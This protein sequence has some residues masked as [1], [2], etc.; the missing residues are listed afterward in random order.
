MFDSFVSP[1]TEVQQAALSMGFFRQEYCRGLPFPSL[2]HLPDTG[3]ESLSPT[4]AGG[5]L[6]TKPP[7]KPIM[8]E[9]SSVK[10]YICPCVF[11]HIH[12]FPQYMCLVHFSHSVVSDSL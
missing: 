5:F 3:I 1:W 12:I 4:L 8:Y 10:I 9:D 7:G 6:T 11:V 2:G